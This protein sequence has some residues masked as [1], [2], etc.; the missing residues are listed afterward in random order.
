MPFWLLCN[1]PISLSIRSRL[2]WDKPAALQWEADADAFVPSLLPCGGLL[3]HPV[4]SLRWAICEHDE[5]KAER[6]WRF[7]N[8][9][10]RA[11]T[12][13][14]DWTAVFNA[15]MDL[16]VS[17]PAPIRV[18]VVR[19]QRA[20]EVQSMPALA[21]VSSLEQT[22]AAALVCRLVVAYEVDASNSGVTSCHPLPPLDPSSGLRFS[23]MRRS[24]TGAE[25]SA[26]PSVMSLSRETMPLCWPKAYHFARMMKRR[27]EVSRTAGDDDDAAAA[28]AAVAAAVAALPAIPLHWSIAGS[29]WEARHR[30]RVLGGLLAGVEVNAVIDNEHDLGG[31]VTWRL[32]SKTR[33]RLA[34]HARTLLLSFASADPSSSSSAAPTSSPEHTRLVNRA[35]EALKKAPA[36]CEQLGITA[37]LADVIE[38]HRES[39]NAGKSGRS[40]G[41]AERLQ[42]RRRAYPM[43]FTAPSRPSAEEGATVALPAPADARPRSSDAR[44][45]SSESVT[46]AAMAAGPPQA[47]SAAQLALTSAPSMMR[48][49]TAAMATGRSVEMRGRTLQLHEEIRVPAGCTLSI[50]GPGTIVGDGHA[51]IRAGGSRQLIEL[52]DLE[53]IHCGSVNRTERRELG[54]AIFALGKSRVR[55]SGCRVTSDQGFGVWMV[56]RARVEITGGSII[57]DCGRSGIVSF[58]HAK[59]AMSGSLIRGCALHGICARGR[60]EVSLADSQ[61]VDAGV[62]GIYAYHNVTLD[63]RR[64]SVRGTRDAAAAAI[65]VEALLP[66]DQCVVRMDAACRFDD[67]NRGAGL[68]MKGNVVVEEV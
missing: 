1:P 51:L 59:L 42:A 65:Q 11:L 47:G 36:E 52:T 61:V 43:G 55:I 38:S 32:P 41:R 12:L 22:L 19:C 15:A 24:R 35:R 16:E 54:G 29:R 45:R 68:L 5:C 8:S 56:Q 26:D 62:R 4:S 9:A 53:L 67:E 28:A 2:P 17:A 20:G 64:S 33:L 14:V 37:A 18:E 57:H 13:P 7:V 30:H 31:G 10:Q 48:L 27:H 6:S 46:A 39:A 58:G 40:G 66:G 34:E 60:S 49:A 21:T 50:R 25:L 3:A 63:M 44:P 23:T